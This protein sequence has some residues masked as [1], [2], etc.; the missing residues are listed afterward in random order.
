M[1]GFDADDLD[2]WHIFTMLMTAMATIQ[3]Y[4]RFRGLIYVDSF[5]NVRAT[6]SARKILEWVRLFCG[7]NY[8]PNV[9]IVT[10][11]W[12]TQD[13]DAISDKLQRFDNWSNS[14]LLKPLLSNGAVSFHHGLIRTKNSWTKLSLTKNSEQREFEARKMIHE[15]YENSSQIQ[16]QVYLEI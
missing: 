11:K 8:M 3:P 2:D 5:D 7:D 4:V 12:D 14:D 10:T 6:K 9:T 15:R 1:P 16:L 13:D